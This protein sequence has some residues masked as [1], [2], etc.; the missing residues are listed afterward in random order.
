MAQT[1]QSPLAGG[2]SIRFEVEDASSGRACRGVGDGPVAMASET[3]QVAIV[4]AG[5]EASLQSTLS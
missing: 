1:I 2:G 5:S 4:K 3:F